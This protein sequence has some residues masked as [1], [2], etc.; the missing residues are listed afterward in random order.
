M[1][2]INGMLGWVV[3]GWV[4]LW[5]WVKVMAVCLIKLFYMDRQDEQFAFIR[6]LFEQHLLRFFLF[7]L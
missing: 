6:G 7:V 4:G 1:N 3:L 5:V 2:V